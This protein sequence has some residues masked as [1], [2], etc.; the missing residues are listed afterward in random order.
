VNWYLPGHPE[1][2]MPI[3]QAKTSLNQDHPVWA[4]L[5]AAPVWHVFYPAVSGPWICGKTCDY[6]VQ[7]YRSGSPADPYLL[8]SKRLDRRFLMCVVQTWRTYR[9][10]NSPF[11]NFRQDAFTPAG[12]GRDELVL[13]RICAD[14]PG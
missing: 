12:G 13:A 6:E 9:W 3:Q 1:A 2:L 8:E 11:A 10:N 14:A 4:R 5:P 7:G